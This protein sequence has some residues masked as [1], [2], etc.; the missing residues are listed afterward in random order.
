M[1]L[2]VKSLEKALRVKGTDLSLESESEIES[3]GHSS[4]SSSATPLTT[5]RQA[6]LSTEFS[7]QEYWSG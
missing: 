1:L 7:R 2:I 6:L 4:V 5:A 3:V